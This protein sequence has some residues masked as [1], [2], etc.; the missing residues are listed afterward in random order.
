MSNTKAY[1][2]YYPHKTTTYPTKK[3]IDAQFPTEMK[4]DQYAWILNGYMLC[5]SDY[6][7]QIT[8]PQIL[9]KQLE[10]SD[11]DT[12]CGYELHQMKDHFNN[13]GLLDFSSF[14]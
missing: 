11:I 9:E 10:R 12:V 4:N 14:H 13:K 6:L 3:E 2:D 1:G 7:S 8:I 5:V